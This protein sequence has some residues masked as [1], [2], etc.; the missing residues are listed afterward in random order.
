[1][2]LQLFP[3]IPGWYTWMCQAS[4]N[5]PLIGYVLYAWMLKF[6]CRSGHYSPCF[7]KRFLGFHS[8]WVFCDLYLVTHNCI[9]GGSLATEVKPARW[10]TTLSKWSLDLMWY[11][12]SLMP[13]AG[14]RQWR[15]R[16]AGQKHN[17]LRSWPNPGR[18]G[19]LIGREL[20]LPFYTFV[21]FQCRRWSTR[22][23]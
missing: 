7:N 13:V 19:C 20:F 11:R 1:M 4:L 17:H 12:C 15:L 9:L 21:W 6:K 16:K 14:N 3:E 8:A 18:W 5:A 23:E 22:E 2:P 10:G